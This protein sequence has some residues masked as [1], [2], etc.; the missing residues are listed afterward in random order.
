MHFRNSAGNAP[1]LASKLDS[2]VAAG[3]WGTVSHLASIDSVTLTPLDGG[4]VS[5]P[6]VPGAVAKWQ[7][8]GGSGDFIPQACTIMKLLT[9]RRGRSYRGRL[10]LPFVP[11]ASQS[12]GTLVTGDVDAEAAAWATFMAAMAGDGYDLVV[13]SYTL[14]TA[15]DV[16]AIAGEYKTATQR[17]RQ[18][19]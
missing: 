16:V 3:M 19:R 4:G 12:Q 6:L 1:D 5:V 13:A 17:R 8:A 15:E 7:G 18:K 14:A 11:E 2:H 9:A 10:F